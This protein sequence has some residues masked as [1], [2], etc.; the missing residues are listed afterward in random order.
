[1]NIGGHGDFKTKRRAERQQT[2]REKS[3]TISYRFTDRLIHWQTD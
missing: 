3:E 1:M 2:K